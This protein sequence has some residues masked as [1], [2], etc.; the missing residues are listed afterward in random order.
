MMLGD[1]ASADDAAQEVFIKAYQAL[2]SFKGNASFST[3]LYR[4][5]SNHC[6]DLLRKRKREKSE[7]WENLI[8]KEGDKIEALLA[9]APEAAQSDRAETAAKV[10]SFLS[11]RARE[12]IVLR[13]MHGLSYQ[14]MAEALGCTL[15]AVKARLKRA[16]QELN[17]KLRHL[18]EFKDV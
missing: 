1:E 2:A 11:E 5:A 14:E 3:W 17:E 13:E 16:R 12:V 6:L 10:L 9:V 4:I 15:D 7:S 8:E 18:L